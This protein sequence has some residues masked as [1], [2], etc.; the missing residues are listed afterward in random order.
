MGN[1]YGER[2]VKFVNIACRC[3]TKRCCEKYVKFRRYPKSAIDDDDDDV[4]VFVRWR[5]LTR[6]RYH[7]SRQRNAVGLS[8]RRILL[9]N[10]SGAAM[11]HGRSPDAT[12][13]TSRI[14]RPLQVWF[15]LVTQCLARVLLRLLSGSPV[16]S[17][18]N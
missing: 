13:Q 16:Q 9:R 8:S 15:E 14:Q 6:S 3:L 18:S 1:Q 17:Y 7:S 12:L 4:K 10:I 2:L 5:A 11:I